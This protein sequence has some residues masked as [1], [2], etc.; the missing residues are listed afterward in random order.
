MGGRTILRWMAYRAIKSSA[1]TLTHVLC[2]FPVEQQALSLVC[3]NDV[4]HTYITMQELRVR[5]SVRYSA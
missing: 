3:Y 2:Q 1:S 5:L 4:P